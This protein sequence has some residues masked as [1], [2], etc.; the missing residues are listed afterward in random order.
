MSLEE[1]HVM[2]SVVLFN[3]YKIFVSCLCFIIAV[4]V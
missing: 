2:Y 3:M 1:L 4:R